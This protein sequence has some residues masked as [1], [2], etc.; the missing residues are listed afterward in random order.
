MIEDQFLSNLGEIHLGNLPPALTSVE[1]ERYLPKTFFTSP[2][3][4]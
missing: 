3:L 4:L 1:A 2:A